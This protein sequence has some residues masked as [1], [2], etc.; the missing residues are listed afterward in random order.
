MGVRG[1]GRISDVSG[2]AGVA[3]GCSTALPCPRTFNQFGV[4]VWI[5]VLYKTGRVW[6]AG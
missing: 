6:L 3:I 4:V 2:V 1:V 5:M